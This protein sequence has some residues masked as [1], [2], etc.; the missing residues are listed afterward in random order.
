MPRYNRKP[1]KGWTTEPVTADPCL[2][3]PGFFSTRLVAGGPHVPCQLFTQE[4]RDED[5]NLIADVQYFAN[6]DGK[7]CDALAPPGWPWKKIT[8]E[9][10]RFL[11][12]DAKWARDHAPDSP[13][14]NPTRP[15]TASPKQYF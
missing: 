10:W 13:K 12:D 7:P 8:E 2:S 11:T 5:G 6:I 9:E 1:G 3:S 14:A 4:E 15:V